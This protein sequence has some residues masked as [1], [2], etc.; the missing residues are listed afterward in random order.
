MRI[1]RFNESKEED[2]N[3][4]K[5]IFDEIRSD[6]L[7]GDADQVKFTTPLRGRY[8]VEINLITPQE[9]ASVNRII[10]SIEKMQKRIEEHNT[11]T[12]V[13]E[14][15]IPALRRLNDQVKTFKLKEKEYGFHIFIETYFETESFYDGI[16]GEGSSLDFDSETFEKYIEDKF[17]IRV[18]AYIN[19]N[20]EGDYRTF[21]LEI[22]F[23]PVNNTKYDDQPIIDE[24]LSLEFTTNGDNKKLLELNRN[25]WG[26]SDN[27]IHFSIN[28]WITDVYIDGELQKWDD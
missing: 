23:F 12:K 5:D 27:V 3:I 18:G 26:N 6:I 15:L 10:N 19:P 9:A 1:R 17:G 8:E 16:K 2:I 4:I 13:M 28:S 25:H 11:R 21:E 7:D 22:E 20:D 24:L 14:S